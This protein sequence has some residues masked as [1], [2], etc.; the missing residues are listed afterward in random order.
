MQGRSGT[1]RLGRVYFY[2]ACSRKECGLRVVAEEAEGAVLDLVGSLSTDPETVATLTAKTSQLLGRKLP[3]FEKQLRTHKRALKRVAAESNALL[4]RDPGDEARLILSQRMRDLAGQ[5]EEI[6]AAVVETEQVLS[7]TRDA[8]VT[9]DA[10]REGLANFERVYAHLKPFEQ[11][12]L[13]RL[14]LHRATIGDRELILEINGEACT[15][16]AQASE[17]ATNRGGF[18]ERA[19][20]LPDEDSNLEPSG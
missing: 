18:T 8:E 20:W 4:T 15:R 14:L 2:Y 3:V 6:E 17:S 13:V 12:E 11:K 7:A 5:R 9:P 10:V 16:F 1:G 19:I